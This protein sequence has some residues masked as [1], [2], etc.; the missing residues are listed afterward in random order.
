MQAQEEKT[1]EKAKN[2]KNVQSKV[3]K[4]NKIVA[5]MIEA[6]FEEAADKE[7]AYTTDEIAEYVETGLNTPQKMTAVMK[8]VTN[9]TRVDKATNEKTRVGYKYQA[10]I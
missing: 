9:A 10:K 2:R 6:F 3:A 1:R 5:E 7:I 4:E 8:Y